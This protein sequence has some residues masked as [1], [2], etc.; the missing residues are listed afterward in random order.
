MAGM[1]TNPQ[2]EVPGASIDIYVNTVTANKNTKVNKN[3]HTVVLVVSETRVNLK[4][5]S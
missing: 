2:S 5:E 1:L 3:A 4:L